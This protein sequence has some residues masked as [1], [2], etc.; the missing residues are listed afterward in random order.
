MRPDTAMKYKN[1]DDLDKLLEEWIKVYEK[2]GEEFSDKKSDTEK[3]I[4]RICNAHKLLSA[5]SNEDNS[6]LDGNFRLFMVK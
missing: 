2:L 5:G 1:G 4:E 6:S 3:L